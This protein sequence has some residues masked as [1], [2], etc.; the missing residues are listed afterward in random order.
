MAALTASSV[1]R[2]ADLSVTY[3]FTSVSD[4][5]TFGVGTNKTR[6]TPVMN[7]DPTT[8]T[9]AGIAYEYNRVTGTVTLRPGENS[10]AA[11]LTVFPVNS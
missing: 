1:V 10:L 8:Q 6:L 3:A 2:N 9:S 5:D 4:G 11:T 7:A